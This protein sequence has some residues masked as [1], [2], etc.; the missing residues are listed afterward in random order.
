[1]AHFWC[2]IL[3]R[4]PLPYSHLGR[5]YGRHYRLLLHKS[6]AEH[7]KRRLRHHISKIGWFESSLQS[8]QRLSRHRT[9]IFF[10]LS[11]RSPTYIQ[12][13]SYVLATSKRSWSGGSTREDMTLMHC[14][15]AI[16]CIVITD[17]T[18]WLTVFSSWFGLQNR[19]LHSHAG[20]HLLVMM[21][22]WYSEGLLSESGG[23]SGGG[24][25]QR[26]FGKRWRG[27]LI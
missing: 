27:Y 15:Y 1:M 22:K 24:G 23:L 6:S 16:S 7:K 19:H 21:G 2:W 13:V 26:R 4:S 20:V 25:I 8:D 17:E 9:A 3:I 5:L 11:E 10:S 14:E 18:L 12:A